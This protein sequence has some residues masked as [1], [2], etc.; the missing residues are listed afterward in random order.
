MLKRF[1][2]GGEE[3]QKNNLTFWQDTVSHF[4]IDELLAVIVGDKNEGLAIKWVAALGLDYQC[5]L[6]DEC[7]AQRR[8]KAAYQVVNEFNL[9]WKFP[10]VERQYK[11]GAVNKM[12]EKRLWGPALVFTGED[13][14]LQVNQRGGHCIMS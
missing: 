8:M 6:V 10:Y 7:I 9:A 13:K 11:E 3:H 14:Q 5:L 12:I 2:A 1:G 4:S